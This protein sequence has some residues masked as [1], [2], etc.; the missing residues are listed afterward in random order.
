LLPRSASWVPCSKSTKLRK[1]NRLYSGFP[2]PKYLA[3]QGIC[4]LSVLGS[5]RSSSASASR[6]GGSHYLRRPPSTVIH[7]DIRTATV[8]SP[9]ASGCWASWF[10]GGSCAAACKRAVAACGRAACSTASAGGELATASRVTWRPWPASMGLLSEAGG[11]SCERGSDPCGDAVFGRYRGGDGGRTQN[12]A[13][14]GCRRRQ[15]LPVAARIL[16]LRRRQLLLAVARAAGVRWLTS[17]R[18]HPADL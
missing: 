13:L 6:P 14:P 16:R 7:T 10:N 8:G 12:T 18:Q 15:Q 17:P 3:K 2:V 5:V 9:I 1:R 11:G 4:H